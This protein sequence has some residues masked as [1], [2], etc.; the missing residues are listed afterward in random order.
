MKVS[1]WDHQGGRPT[2]EAEK[3][4]PDNV[5]AALV[6]ETIQGRL[7]VPAVATYFRIIDAGEHRGR[8]A[9]EG[10]PPTCAVI[11]GS[12]ELIEKQKVTAI[13]ENDEWWLCSSW[14]MVDAGAGRKGRRGRFC[15]AWDKVGGYYRLVPTA[16]L[17][18]PPPPSSCWTYKCKM[19]KSPFVADGKSLLW[20]RTPPV[21]AVEASALSE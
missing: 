12:T 20:T 3:A 5:V 6:L 15:I 9:W 18:L 21:A 2:P 17:K 16:C 10:W 13:L 14:K 19:V 8:A 1:G 11:P 7:P 4:G